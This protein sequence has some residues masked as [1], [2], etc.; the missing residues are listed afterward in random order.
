[1]A[2][3]N[4]FGGIAPRD[5]DPEDAYDVADPPVRRLEV[6][7]RVVDDLTVRG[8]ADGRLDVRRR[9]ALRLLDNIE[10]EPGVDLLRVAELL[11]ELAAL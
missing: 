1:M 9:N 4:V 7:A 10:A 2:A 5:F 3:V 6:I 8:D 11:A